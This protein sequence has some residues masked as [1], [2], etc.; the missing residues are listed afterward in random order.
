MSSSIII[1]LILATIVVFTISLIFLVGNFFERLIN[2]IF[3]SSGGQ[4]CVLSV[5]SEIGENEI[6]LTIKNDGKYNIKLAAVEGLNLDD[7]KFYPIPYFD[8]KEFKSI[9]GK[10]LRNQFAKKSLSPKQTVS[11]FL[12]KREIDYTSCLGLNVLDGSGNAWDA[13]N[14][15]VIERPLPQTRRQ[16]G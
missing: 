7:S 15:K 10:V 9:S 2:W 16:D 1:Y 13:K 3:G 8:K 6:I 12:N 4:P 14:F 11:V 5:S